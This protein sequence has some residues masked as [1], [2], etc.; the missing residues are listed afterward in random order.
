MNQ[1]TM[2]DFV[3]KMVED[4]EEKIA[5]LESDIREVKATRAQVIK[6]YGNGGCAP[7]HPTGPGMGECPLLPEEMY[8]IGGR[9]QILRAIAE[10]APGGRVHTRKVAEW[11]HH[12][13]FLGTAPLILAKT[14]SRRMRQQADIWIDEK[15]GWFRLRNFPGLPESLPRDAPGPCEEE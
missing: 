6:Q 9:H 14:L 5:D 10:R 7:V 15:G 3:V 12:A 13:G 4:L 8:A 11:L 2:P 1:P